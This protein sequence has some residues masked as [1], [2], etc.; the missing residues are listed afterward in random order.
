M[1]RNFKK[2]LHGLILVYLMLALISPFF[3]SVEANSMT[4]TLTPIDDAYV[5]SDAANLNFGSETVLKVGYKS[6]A[7]DCH[8]YIKFD[9]SSIPE[10]AVIV[11]AR[12]KLVDNKDSPS[13]VNVDVHRVMGD[14][15]ESSIKWSNKP[16]YDST[17]ISNAASGASGDVIEWDVTDLVQAWVNGTYDNYG[18]VLI[19]GYADP[20]EEFRSKETSN[21]DDKPKLVIEY[22]EPNTVTTT[23]TQT[24]TE[25][26]TINNTVTET[27]TTTVANTTYTVYETVSPTYGNQTANYYTDLANQLIPLVMVIGVICTM[28]SLLLS[29]TAGRR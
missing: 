11:S 18:L 22:V 7:Y 4:V 10:N 6:G 16:D 25:T 23:V 24:I 17:V 14:W 2:I 21:S 29:A 15:D 20:V 26:Q 9:L 1:A 3:L 27:V 12:L 5:C 13:N 28:L 8:S 19:G